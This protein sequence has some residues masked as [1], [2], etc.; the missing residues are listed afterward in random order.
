MRRKRDVAVSHDGSVDALRHIGRAP[1]DNA[2]VIVNFDL[3]LRRN[4]APRLDAAGLAFGDEILT[5]SRCEREGKKDQTQSTGRKLHDR[6][7][8]AEYREM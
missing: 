5:R 2:P 6:T 8:R 7:F 3:P 1:F 4:T